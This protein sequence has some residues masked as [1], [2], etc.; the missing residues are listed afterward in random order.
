[1]RAEV[2]SVLCTKVL[3]LQQ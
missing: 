3:S 2:V 1:M